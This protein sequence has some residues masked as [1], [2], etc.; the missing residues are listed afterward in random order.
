MQHF[1]SKFAIDPDI[2]NTVFKLQE[3]YRIL[4]LAEILASRSS[5]VSKHVFCLVFVT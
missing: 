3:G 4:F 1:N 2:R 5:L